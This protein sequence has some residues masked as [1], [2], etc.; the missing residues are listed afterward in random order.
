LTF[1][2]GVVGVGDRGVCGTMF[3]VAFDNASI[4]REFDTSEIVVTLE[5]RFEHR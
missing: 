5:V 3:K 2:K 4:Y 1:E